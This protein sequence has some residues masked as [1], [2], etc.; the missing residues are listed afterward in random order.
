MVTA[1]D[2]LNHVRDAEYSLWWAVRYGIHCDEEALAKQQASLS[3][4]L[5]AIDEFAGALRQMLA[6]ALIETGEVA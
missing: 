5:D 1:N 6:E 4:S 2:L 3:L